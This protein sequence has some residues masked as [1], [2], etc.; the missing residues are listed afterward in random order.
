M[1]RYEICKIEKQANILMAKGDD[2]TLNQCHK[3][4]FAKKKI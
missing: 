1:K 2:F 3:N 4:D